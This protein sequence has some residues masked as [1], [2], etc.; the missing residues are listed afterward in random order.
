MQRSGERQELLHGPLYYAAAHVAATLLFW[1]HSPAG[2][3]GLA[4][5][6]GGDGLAEVVGRSIRTPRLPHNR[7]KSVGGSMA[8]WLGGASTAW[9]LLA[10]YQHLGM[11]AQVPQAALLQGAP[12]LQGVLLCAAVRP[13]HELDNLAVTA[14]VALTTRWYFGF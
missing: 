6:C 14:S 4:V 2:V 10:Y 5:L 1:R 13:L 7:N 11:F 8:C 12:L 9:P 3:L